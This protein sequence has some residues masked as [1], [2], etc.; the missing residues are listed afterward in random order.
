[1]TKDEQTWQEKLAFVLAF[2]KAL[3]EIVVFAR[4]GLKLGAPPE[5][6]ALLSMARKR[7]D[8]VEGQ[9]ALFGSKTPP[10]KPQ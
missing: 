5:P 8:E 3:A 9:S 6:S 2:V 7:L 1:M 4:R 10:N